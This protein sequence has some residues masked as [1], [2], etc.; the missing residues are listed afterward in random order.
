MIN[1][2]KL[3][4]IQ[5]PRWACNDPDHDHKTEK[6][7]QLCIRKQLKPKK[8]IIVWTQEKLDDVIA[9][10]DAG[11]PLKTIAASYGVSA[12]RIRQVEVRERRRLRRSFEVGADALSSQINHSFFNADEPAINIESLGLTIRT[13]N[14]LLAEKIYTAQQAAKLSRDELLRIP[15]MGKKSV[16]ELIEALIRG[17]VI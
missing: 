2:P 12:E 4:F 7:A 5:I 10:Y 15:N 17:G 16:N 14:S 6:S 8:A 9:R 13:L 11:Q 3:Y 1:N